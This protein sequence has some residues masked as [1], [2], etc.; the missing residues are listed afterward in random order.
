LHHF[1]TQGRVRSRFNLF[2]INA[3][4]GQE[5]KRATTKG[6]KRFGVNRHLAHDG[7]PKE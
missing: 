3:L 2:E 4:L 5:R 1:L 6:A 7:P